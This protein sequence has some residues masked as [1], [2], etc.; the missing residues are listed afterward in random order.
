[1][2]NSVRPTAV[3]KEER[4]LSL[5][6]LMSLT[7][8]VPDPLPFDLHSSWPWVMSSA[9]KNNVPPRAVRDEGLEDRAKEPPS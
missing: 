6:G 5:P 3:M 2:K 7:M 9:A 1:M 8:T 4:L